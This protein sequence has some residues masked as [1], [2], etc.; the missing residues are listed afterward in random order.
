MNLKITFAHDVN[1]KMCKINDYVDLHVHD[2]N[3]SMDMSMNMNR[4]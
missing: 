2:I 4:I 3:M 1:L